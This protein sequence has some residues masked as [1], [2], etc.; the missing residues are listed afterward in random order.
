MAKEFFNNSPDTSTPLNASR[1]NGLL[2]GVEAMGNILVGDVKC[3][4]LWS[5]GSTITSERNTDVNLNDYIPA[6]TYTMSW[7][8]MTT[9]SETTPLMSFRNASGNSVLELF[10]PLDKN[11]ITFVLPYAVYM[12]RFYPS[13]NY[14]NSQG[15]TT[16]LENV[17]IE[18]GTTA[19]EYT[20]YKTFGIE[21]GSNSNGSWIKFENGTLI[22][23]ANPTVNDAEKINFPIE[24]KDLGYAMTTFAGYANTPDVV[25]TWG[26]KTIS[27]IQIFIRTDGTTAG[28]S[29]PIMWTAI[30]RW[31]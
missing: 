16:V 26:S 12:Y 3:K 29:Q 6:G 20:P 19:T 5:N 18:K 14:N 21:S 30:G 1:L 23:Y 2:N 17:Q 27:S 8:T 9:D 7:G 15:K 10:L 24:F 25:I 11:S 13:N 22:Q 28:A 31:K 4:N